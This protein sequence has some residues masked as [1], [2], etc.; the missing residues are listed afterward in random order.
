MTLLGLSTCPWQD[1][2]L[3]R[4]RIP[5]MRLR[6]AD[7]LCVARNADRS[8]PSAIR[9]VR[10]QNGLRNKTLRAYAARASV[11]FAGAASYQP[12]LRDCRR[13]EALP[14]RANCGG[15]DGTGPY[16]PPHRCR[17]I[18]GPAN[19]KSSEGKRPPVGGSSGQSRRTTPGKSGSG[20]F[21]HITHPF[22]PLAGQELERASGP[23]H[24]SHRLVWFHTA[25]GRLSPIPLAFTDLVEPDPFVV[26]SAG[27]AHLGVKDLLRLAEFVRQAKKDSQGGV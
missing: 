19:R 2:S 11:S 6:S 21:F 9:D 10:P 23:P 15:I 16:R 22:H 18:G 4:T 17:G 27:R 5:L 1:S 12:E 20:A 25:D 3:S 24:E 26:V 7:P 8:L 13:S 14:R